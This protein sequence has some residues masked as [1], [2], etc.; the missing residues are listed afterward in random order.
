MADIDEKEQDTGFLNRWSRRKNQNVEENNS[1]EQELVAKAEQQEV[2]ERELKT[3]D[4]MPALESLT[5]ESDYTGF[6]SPKVSE[7]LRKQALRKLF[8]MPSLNI[9]DGLDDYAEDFTN[10][11]PLGDLVTE[12]M[13]RV[14]IREKK[15]ADEQ[16]EAEAQAEAKAE[17]ADDDAVDQTEVE[18]NDEDSELAESIEVSDGIESEHESA[19]LDIPP[20]EKIDIK[21]DN[22]KHE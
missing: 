7:V 17:N 18:I 21:L 20:A 1:K 2:S 10:F 15:K 4:D 9:V 3:D 16:A 8:H 22:P 19:S 6:L 14:L 5:E 13:K 11:A 12:E